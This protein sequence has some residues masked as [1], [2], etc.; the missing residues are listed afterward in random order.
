MKVASVEWNRRRYIVLLIGI[1]ATT[2]ELKYWNVKQRVL[3]IINVILINHV[4]YQ[5]R[6][7]PK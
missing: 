1:E 6:S 4:T 5:I 7:N 2:L 3:Y